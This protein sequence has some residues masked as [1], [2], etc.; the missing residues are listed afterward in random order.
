MFEEALSLPAD[1]RLSLVEKLLASLN[2]PVQQEIERLWAEEA[3]R[4]VAEIDAGE[5]QL[6]PGD[7]VF[8]KIKEEI[9]EFEAEHG[10]G[11]KERLKD[12]LGDIF[13]AIVNVSRFLD[14]R[15]EDALNGTI[16]KFKTRFANVEQEISRRGSMTLAEMD[17]I[18]EASKKK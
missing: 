16:Q 9:G 7:D 6:V 5:V 2:L 15:A 17:E 8:A 10:G 4:R 18:W 12:E 3:E 14:I 1:A 11:T 13:F